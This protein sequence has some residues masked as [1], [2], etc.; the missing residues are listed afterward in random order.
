GSVADA[1]HHRFN[2]GEPSI[3]YLSL[4]GAD[5]WAVEVVPNPDKSPAFTCMGNCRQSAASSITR[6]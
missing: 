3:G 2:S 1:E 4:A 6:T 5:T